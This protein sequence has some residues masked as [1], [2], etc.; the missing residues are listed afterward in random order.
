MRKII[1]LKAESTKQKQN[2]RETIKQIAGENCEIDKL[3]FKLE[4]RKRI[5]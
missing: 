1:K 5:Y 4:G 2:Y 3:V